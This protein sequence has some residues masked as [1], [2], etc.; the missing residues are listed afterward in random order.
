MPAGPIVSNMKCPEC[1]TE[2]EPK[3]KKGVRDVK[4]QSHLIGYISKSVMLVRPLL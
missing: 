3:S 4:E 2:N 1:G